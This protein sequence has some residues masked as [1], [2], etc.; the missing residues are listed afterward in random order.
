[1]EMRAVLNILLLLAAYSAST[2]SQL[3]C[4]GV[5]NLKPSVSLSI[6][7]QSKM[8]FLRPN[9]M[10][11]DL[12]IKLSDTSLHVVGFK[13]VIPCQSGSV[14]FDMIVRIYYGDRIKST[15]KILNLM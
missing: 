9:D 14:T 7:N 13:L 11:F 2:Q 12:I 15:D 6:N 5:C 4:N 10:D 3:I 1:M 8:R